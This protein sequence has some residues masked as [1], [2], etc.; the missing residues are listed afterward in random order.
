MSFGTGQCWKLILF[1]SRLKMKCVP[2]LSQVY[3]DRFSRGKVA[4]NRRL[5]ARLR[6]NIKVKTITIVDRRSGRKIQKKTTTYFSIPAEFWMMIVL[7]A[8]LSQTC[9]WGFLYQIL[10]TCKKSEKCS[11]IDNIGEISG[12]ITRRGRPLSSIFGAKTHANVQIMF[13]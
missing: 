6:L 4:R 13:V 7:H 2:L 8:V 1:I 9:G 12:H 5:S 11:Q 3:L 10:G